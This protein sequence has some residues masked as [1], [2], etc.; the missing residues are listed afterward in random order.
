[1]IQASFGGFGFYFPSQSPPLTEVVKS[2]GVPGPS[3]TATTLRSSANPSVI[4]QKLSYTATVRPVPNGGTVRFLQGGNTIAGC[5][6]VPVRAPSGQ[7]VCD[8]AYGTAGSREV[9]AAYSGNTSFVGSQSSSVTQSVRPSVTLNGQLGISSSGVSF[10][11]SC[12]ARSGGCQVTGTLTTSVTVTGGKL[13]RTSGSRHRTVTIGK[14]RMKIAAGKSGTLVVTLGK[15]GRAMLH[16]VQRLTATLK[17]TLASGGRQITI[18]T[19][20]LTLRAP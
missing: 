18:A 15:S 5:G 13:A 16:R 10:R 1:V 4:G 8:A 20:R 19:R 7:A 3:A 14:H 12:A 2:P 6:A 11:L 17:I 9:Q